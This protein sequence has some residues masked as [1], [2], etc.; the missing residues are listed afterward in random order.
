[1]Q[2]S[3]GVKVHVA[4]Y[5][6]QADNRQYIVPR[7]DRWLRNAATKVGSALGRSWKSFSKCLPQH[8]EPCG[9]CATTPCASSNNLPPQQKT[10]HLSMCMD[11]T[12]RRKIVHQ[13]RVDSF[14][15]D[16]QL[17]CFLQKQ[18]TA[19]SSRFPNLLRL[20][21]VEKIVFVKYLLPM[22]GIIDVQRCNSTRPNQKNCYC[23]PPPK[24]VGVEYD[25]RPSPPK[26]H[27]PISPEYLASWF[28]CT[29]DIPKVDKDQECWILNRLPKRTCGVLE[30]R[31]EDPAEG[32][33]IYFVEGWDRATITLTIFVIFLVASLLF[34]VLW[35]KFQFDIQGGFGVSAYIG[36]V[37]TLLI[38]VIVT[39]L[40]NKE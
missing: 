13:D 35:S 6:H 37:C 39:Q 18:Y 17:L 1:M 5:N 32:W 15:T 2:Q 38:A 28:T 26:T 22:N 10:L 23:I 20:K 11:R 25:Y 8:N 24:K 12:R 14:K 16:R 34:G 21:S 30:G 7:P 29:K 33:G 4:P 40:E 19:H 27:P 9:T 3:S 36:T 31:K